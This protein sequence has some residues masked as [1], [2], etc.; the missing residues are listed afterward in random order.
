MKKIISYLLFATIIAGMLSG[1]KRQTDKSDSFTIVTS[2]APVYA[3]T[4]TITDGSDVNVVNMAESVTGCVHDYQLST[5]N[6]RTV[7]TADLFIT[8][9]SGMENNFIDKI[10]S[11]YTDLTVIDSS[12]GITN[13]LADSEH[14]HESASESHEEE[15][16][17]P[18]TWMSL[19]NA[20][21]QVK[22]IA[23]ALI[24]HNPEN[25]AIYEKNADNFRSQIEEIK[26]EFTEKF[27]SLA[28]NKIVIFHESFE[29]LAAEF[30]LTVTNIISDSEGNAPDPQQ[31]QSVINSINQEDVHVIVTEPQY[32]DST[33]NV[34]AT[35]TGAVVYSLDPLVTGTMNA[36]S[37]V[38]VMRSNLEVLYNA[39][40]NI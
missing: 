4:L 30:N 27:D 40:K 36:A 21:A 37:Y 34:I 25:K 3:L 24:T 6:M 12:E 8:N 19:E 28:N 18:H 1:C 9:G 38:T 2:F 10:T 14:D 5:A 11:Q 26:L 15:E 13:L 22:N 29:Y 33:A 35:D 17:N 23:N 16:V 7:E 32:S 31:I 20:A 39:L